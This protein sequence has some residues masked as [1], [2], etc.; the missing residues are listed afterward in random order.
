VE[1]QIVLLDTSVLI[2]FFRKKDKSKTFLFKLGSDYLSFA[3]SSITLFEIYTGAHESQIELWDIFFKDVRVIPLDIHIA[4]LSAKIDLQL[5]RSNKR[6]D[7]AD[8]FIAAT[9]I[10]SDLPCATSNKKHFERI[11]DLQLVD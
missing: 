6:I 2:D 10:Y 1:N 5:K 3:V 8:L 7:K 9:A 11:D 4:M